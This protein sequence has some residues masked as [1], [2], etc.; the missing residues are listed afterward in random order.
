MQD[1]WTVTDRLTMNYGLRYDIEWLSKYRGL[2]YG[3]DRNNFGPRLALSYDLTGKGRTLLK[4]SNGLYYD[5][6][7]QNPITPTF[8]ENKETLQQVSGT[9][10]FGDAGAPVYPQTFENQPSAVPQS[11]RNVYIVPDAGKMRVPASYQVVGSLDHAFRDDLAVTASVLYSRSWDK[12]RLYDV[13]IVFND[14]TQAFVRPDPTFRIINQYAYEGKAEYTGIVL[15]V[16]KRMQSGFFY[17]A[18]ATWARAF[19]EGNNFSSPPDDPRYPEREW[20]P[21]ADTPKF[22]MT[23]NGSYE[24]NKLMS[25]SAIFRARTG[26][27]VDPRVPGTLDPNGD[28][29]FGDRTPGLSRNS[30][31]MPGNNSLDMRFTFNLPLGSGRCSAAQ[32]TDRGLQPSTTATTCGRSSRS[33][34]SWRTQPQD[35]FLDP[36]TYSTRGSCSSAFGSCSR[37]H[38]G[39]RQAALGSGASVMHIR[40]RWLAVTAIALVS[41]MGTPRAQSRQA[42]PP[43]AAKK[44]LALVGGM[45][46]DGYEVPPLHHAA[47]LIEDNKIVAV[48]PAADVK[49]PPERDRH[50]H[51]GPDDDARDDG[52]AR[53]PDDPR[54]WQLRR[55]V[56][57]D[58]QARRAT[59]D[60]D[61]GQAARQRRHH[62]SRRSV[63]AA[64]GE[65]RSCATASR[66]AR[67]L[68]RA[69]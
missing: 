17:S 28:G 60:G 57:V 59:R 12:E 16:R 41:T 63:G 62:D 51:L 3:H 46:L 50:R 66:A 44:T 34:A 7:F 53:A 58:C 4:F 52:F 54:A 35:I 33:T 42:A 30:F 39:R 37:P 40:S 64:Q 69:C 49:I 13:N 2:D 26:F 1:S 68:D 6:I 65:P 5:R 24:F 18:N 22:R 38:S 29:I 10:N 15:E 32:A 8:F 20:G 45:L 61:L 27:A 21:Q 9:W 25:L 56:S 11:V 23:A 14:A 43:P 31:R 47:I 36:L 48:G 19:D 55:L 67:F